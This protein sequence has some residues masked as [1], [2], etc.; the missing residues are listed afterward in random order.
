MLPLDI[1]TTVPLRVAFR[2]IGCKLNQCE[3]AQMQQ[4]FLDEGCRVVEWNDE[5]DVR[6]INTCTVTAKSDRTCRREIRLAKRM[7]PEC[8]LAVTGCYAEV[9]PQAVKTIPGVDLVLGNA[10]KPRLAA[11]VARLRRA[12]VPTDGDT[13]NEFIAHFYGYTRAF[14]KIQTGCDSRCAYCI[15]PM[16]RGAGRSMALDDVLKQV[17]ILAAR[18]YQEVVLTGINLGSWRL[19][20]PETSD[21]DAGAVPPRAAAER[22]TEGAEGNLAELMTALLDGTAMRRFR[23]SSLEPLQV[24]DH[25]L[26]VIAAGGDRV[27]RHFHLPLQSGSAEILRRMNRPYDPATYLGI[28]ERIADRF[29]DAAIGADVIVGFPGETDEEFEE[30]YRFIKLSPLTYLH[31]FAYS[32]R[33]GTTAS[34]MGGK[35]PAGAIQAR[36]R[37]LRALGRSLTA[38]F[39]KRMAGSRQTALI[40]RE[41]SADGRL[42]GL[43]GNYIEV[44]LAGNDDLMNQM[45]TGVLVASEQGGSFGFQPETL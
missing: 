25:L 36:S 12:D 21:T 27:A 43:T 32:D 31:V 18:A 24:S 3:T 45:L 22:G 13:N 6:V 11:Q 30:T 28:V 37:R 17:E 20:A 26:D 15:I 14:L 8:V 34:T 1:Q 42:Q 33:P 5:A 41:R 44:A 7:D 29:P 16:A 40:L 9:A 38:R 35:V 10:D 39:H 23:L 2:T 4:S 19:S